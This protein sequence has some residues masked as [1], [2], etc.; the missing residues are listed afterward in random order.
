MCVKYLEA[1]L[2]FFEDIGIF[3]TKLALF[4]DFSNKSNFKMSKSFQFADIS[5]QLF[6]YMAAFHSA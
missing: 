6:P 4:T 3:V 1:V 2:S 5:G